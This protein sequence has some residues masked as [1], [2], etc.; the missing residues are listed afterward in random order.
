MAAPAMGD[1]IS[2]PPPRRQQDGTG[3]VGMVIFLASWAMMFAALFFA[4]GVVRLRSQVWPPLGEPRLPVT[5]P[6]LNTIALFA[7]SLTFQFAIAGVRRGKTWVTPALGATTALGAWFLCWQ[8][9][10]WL[11]VLGSGVR[12]S[13]GPYASVFYGLT[14]FHGL[15][16]LVGVIALAL[17]TVRARAGAFT[18]PRHQSLRLWA[19]YWHFVGVVW[20]VLFVTVYLI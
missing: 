18:A 16:V 5:L 15:H 14:W 13:S 20:A 3:F 6:A 11:R 9:I 19:M 2:Y 10:G 1:L 7:S 12:P 17:L 4:Y 8:T